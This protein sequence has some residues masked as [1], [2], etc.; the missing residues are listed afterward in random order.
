MRGDLD[1]ALLGL[2]CKCTSLESRLLGP[3]FGHHANRLD[4]LNGVA[5]RPRISEHRMFSNLPAAR[6]FFHQ[7]PIW[8]IVK[9][10]RRTR[11]AGRADLL[12]LGFQ[13]LQF[14]FSL[15]LRRR[16][17]H[18]LRC[19]AYSGSVGR[20]CLGRFGRRPR[21]PTSTSYRFR[22]RRRRRRRCSLRWTLRRSLRWSLHWLCQ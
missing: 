3:V 17:D 13:V 19:S 16:P 10:S 21:P 1:Y 18:S 20:R 11:P 8:A 9:G 15:T 22:F 14:P 6:F 4:R 12:A 7:P 2:R 5:L